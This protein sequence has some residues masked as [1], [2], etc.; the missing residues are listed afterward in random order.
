LP[1]ST[2]SRSSGRTRMASCASRPTSR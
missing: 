1:A 2:S